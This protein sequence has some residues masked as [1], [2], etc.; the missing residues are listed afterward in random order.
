L[1]TNS[2]QAF[3]EFYFECRGQ[4]VSKV[5]LFGRVH[6]N[7]ENHDSYTH[8]VQRRELV[9]YQ[10]VRYAPGIFQEYVPKRVELRVTV[11]GSRVFAA[12]IH[13][14]DSRLTRDDWRHYDND[15]ATYAPHA[16][17]KSI[18]NLCLQLV[19]ALHLS[20]G[21]IDLVL[22]PQ[23]E[24]VFLEINPN[25]QWVWVQ[26]LAGLP[27]AEAIAEL[28]FQGTKADRRETVDEQCLQ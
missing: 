25:G 4:L 26:E 18:E 2:P 16:L 21:A 17:P 24:Y 5:I 28:L 22:T 3:L 23:G 13:S 10:S 27:I 11:V 6:R 7:G 12:E 14:Q 15:R 1:V 8:V 9:G 20:F 19:R